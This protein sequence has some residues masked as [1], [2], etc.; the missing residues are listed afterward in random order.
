MRYHGTLLAFI[1]GAVDTFSFLSLSGLFAA[2]VTG[3]F[4]ILGATIVLGHPAG[5]WSKVLVVPLFGGGVWAASAGGAALQRRHW[6]LLR[7]LLGV[8]L[9]LLLAALGVAV[10][11]GPFDDAD[12]HAALLLGGLL[13]LAMG[14]QAA[15]GPLAAPQEPPTNVLTTT[16]TR[17]V[18]GVS[19]LAARQFA[20]DS[21]RRRTR[22]AV[23]R[24][25]GQC[26]AFS[27]GCATSA[28]GHVLI[29]MWSVAIPALAVAIALAASTERDPNAQHR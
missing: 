6:S 25:A 21:E 7:P 5:V 1:A 10:G 11:L 23:V 28:A 18:I 3:N 14:T 19:A 12:G 26:V 24:L 20:S 2:H 22:Q 13:T 4:A 29:G 27:V 17:M 8:E 16:F 15:M 9:V